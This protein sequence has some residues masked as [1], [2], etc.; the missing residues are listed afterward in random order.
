[1]QAHAADPETAKET[2]WRLL[3]FLASTHQKTPPGPRRDLI[4]SE[5]K[6]HAGKWRNTYT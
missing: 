2:L 1:M 3:L 6:M 5:F 4:R